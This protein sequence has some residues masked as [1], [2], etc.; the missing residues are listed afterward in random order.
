MSWCF[1]PLSLCDKNPLFTFTFFPS[2]KI[3]NWQHYRSPF[4]SLSCFSYFS[5]SKNPF[6]HHKKRENDL[7]PDQSGWPSFMLS[8][9]NAHT[10]TRLSTF[11]W[12]APGFIEIL[13]EGLHYTSIFSLIFILLLLSQNMPVFSHIRQCNHRGQVFTTRLFQTVYYEIWV[14]A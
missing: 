8:D 3:D 7:L 10:L 2:P 14:N 4:P 11:E 1:V 13:P 5:W 6:S 12:K 9:F